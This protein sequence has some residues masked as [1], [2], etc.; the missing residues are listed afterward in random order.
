MITP[1]FDTFPQGFGTLSM[2]L[3]FSAPREDIQAVTNTGQGPFAVSCLLIR[4]PAPSLVGDTS[5]PRPWWVIC[6]GLVCS[7]AWDQPDWNAA[8]PQ[9]GAAAVSCVVRQLQDMGWGCSIHQQP[10]RWG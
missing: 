5:R 7:A 10:S 3:Y 2:V 4:S 1:S 9:P 8:T 6:Q